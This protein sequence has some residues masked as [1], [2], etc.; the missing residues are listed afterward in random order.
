MHK[1]RL[2]LLMI[3]FVFSKRVQ[4]LYD[5]AF[6]SSIT[7]PAKLSGVKPR[8]VVEPWDS[9]KNLEILTG[10]F[11]RRDKFEEYFRQGFFTLI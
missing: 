11:F 2:I 10:H 5:L 7:R 8:V 9:V 3:S 1:F 6:T 4:V